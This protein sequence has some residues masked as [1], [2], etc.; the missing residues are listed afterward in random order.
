MIGLSVLERR[1][2]GKIRQHNNGKKKK[3]KASK[4]QVVKNKQE[5]DFQGL[6]SPP[7]PTGALGY[8]GPR[9]S[10]FSTAVVER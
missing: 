1:L 6:N 4:G 3:I 8:C 5:S 2:R 9:V 7:P 10:V